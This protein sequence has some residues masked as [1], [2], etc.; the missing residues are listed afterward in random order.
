[1]DAYHI[2]DVILSNDLDENSIASS[3]SVQS[4]NNTSSNDTE[5]STS[6]HESE[7]QATSVSIDLTSSQLQEISVSG[8]TRDTF[9]LYNQQIQY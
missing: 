5:Q 4:R 7:S 6:G 9:V 2:M 1:V 3:S 8:D